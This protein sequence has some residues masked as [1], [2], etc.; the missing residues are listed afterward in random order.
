M[1]N[2]IQTYYTVDSLAGRQFSQFDDCFHEDG[3]QM[4]FSEAEEIHAML[5]KEGVRHHS[6]TKHT[7]QPNG[8]WHEETV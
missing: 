1:L 6:I 8:V 3:D 5:T 2:L 4:E 7:K